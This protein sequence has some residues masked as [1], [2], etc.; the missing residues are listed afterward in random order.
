MGSEAHAT[1]L[2]R[3]ARGYLIEIGLD[4]SE[5]YA[6]RYASVFDFLVQVPRADGSIL[7][8]DL[9]TDG[10]AWHHTKSQRQR[11]LMRDKTTRSMGIEVV[12]LREGFNGHTL[13]GALLQV[14]RRNG[15]VDFPKCP[16][17]FPETSGD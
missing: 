12:R 7:S 1:C 16:T 9:E 5:Q 17:S 11:D 8:I 13:Y 4:F 2:E 6:T 3:Q 15:V 14:A 10:S